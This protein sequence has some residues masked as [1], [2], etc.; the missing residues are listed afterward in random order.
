[1]NWRPKRVTDC[2]RVASAN[3]PPV[4]EALAIV[5]SWPSGYSLLIAPLV[6][7]Q[8]LVFVPS[9]LMYWTRRLMSPE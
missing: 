2:G 1:M 8:S 6:K 4:A 5:V 7:C 3:V 9:G